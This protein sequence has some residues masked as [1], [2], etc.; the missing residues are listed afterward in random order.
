MQPDCQSRQSQFVGVGVFFLGGCLGVFVGVGVR[1]AVGGPKVAVGGTGVGV[2]DAV[3][4]AVGVA[5][6]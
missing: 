5:G 4:V 6:G 3:R 2:A 1:V